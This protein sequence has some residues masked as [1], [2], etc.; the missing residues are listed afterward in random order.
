MKIGS[1][2]A[3]VHPVFAGKVRR[4]AV[5]D[6]NLLGLRGAGP[7]DTVASKSK[8]FPSMHLRILAPAVIAAAVS[9]FIPGCKK[10]DAALRDNV[11]R[12]R[13]VS[14][15]PSITETVYALGAQEHLV[16]VT[17]FCSWPPEAKL[18][19]R[20]GGYVDPNYEQIMRLKPDVALLLK[21][22][23]SLISFLK[24][25]K[26]DIV[27]FDNRNIAAIFSTIAA[28]GETC[29]VPER[30]DSLVGVI[31]AEL[32]KQPAGLPLHKKP[33]ILFCVGRDKPGSGTIGSVFCAGPGSFYSELIDFAGGENVFN[34]S[35]LVYPSVAAEGIIRLAPDIIIDAMASNKSMDPQKV[36]DDWK[37]LEMV[38][39]VER[40]SVYALTGSHV[41]IPGPR[42]GKICSDICN[43]INDWNLRCSREG[44]CLHFK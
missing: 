18:L 10:H 8:H 20:V 7:E 40:G 17:D 4:P 12:P 15:A 1:G 19:P 22:H 2:P 14:F 23:G 37:V 21:E 32:R 27:T 44:E 36:R 16:G 41:S 30:A 28:I 39:A 38:P 34:D 6:F 33:R 26:V 5:A 29:G 25:H 3:T 35:L 24:N 11:P 13:I 31:S 9:L 42:I 43:C